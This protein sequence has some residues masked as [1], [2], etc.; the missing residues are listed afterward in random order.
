MSKE[1]I[2]HSPD[3]QALLREGYELEII[4]NDSY[5]LIHNVPYVTPAKV[6][7]RGTLVSVLNHSG[8]Q[9]IKPETHVAFFIGECPSEANGKPIHFVIGSNAQVI[10]ENCEINH[11]LSAKADYPDHCAKM[12]H[13]IKVLEHQ[14]NEIEPGIS[15]ATYK[16]HQPVEENSVFEYADTNSAK[17]LINPITKKLEGQKVAIIGM[18]GTGSYLLDMLAKN[19]VAEIHLFDGDDF[20]QH[21]AFRAPGAPSTEKLRE[22]LKKVH[23][24]KEIYSNM[25]KGIVAH[26]YYIGPDNLHELGEITVLFLS[27]DSSPEKKAIIEYSLSRNIPVIHTG[28]GLQ[29]VGGKIRGQVK[30]ATIDQRK[31]DHVDAKI[32][33]SDPEEDVYDQN[34]QIADLNALNAIFAVIRWK[35]MFG[36]YVDHESEYFSNYVLF[37]NEIHNSELPV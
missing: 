10:C 36:F 14:A 34:I 3:L 1:L 29:D 26:P 21:N 20:F 9:T 5:M 13:Y 7:A 37:T 11:T 17:A 12:T 22:R 2:S 31:N 23:Y 19:P 15:A 24:F 33:Y 6:V 28:I 16:V 4:A 18:G 25:H 32:S 27:M 35:K 8:G 30:V